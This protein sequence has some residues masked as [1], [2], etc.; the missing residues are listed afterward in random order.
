MVNNSSDRYYKKSKE[1]LQK[2]AYE[3]YQNFSEEKK[4]KAA[5]W[6]RKIHKSY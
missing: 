6:S 3:R 4:K 5:I 2:Q 1:R